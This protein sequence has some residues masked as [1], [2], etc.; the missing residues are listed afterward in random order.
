MRTMR[1]QH[2][3]PCRW[4]CVSV[5]LI[6]ILSLG[7]C[8]SRPDAATPRPRRPR[9]GR[10]LSRTRSRPD[11]VSRPSVRGSPNRAMAFDPSRKLLATTSASGITLWD[12]RT[13]VEVR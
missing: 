5:A 2:A 1:E 3:H 8:R 10:R 4:L 6:A 11:R 9:Q 12:L 13:R 7:A